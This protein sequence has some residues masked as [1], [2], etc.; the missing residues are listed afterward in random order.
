ML[1]MRLF[2]GWGLC[3][4]KKDWKLEGARMSCPKGFIKFTFWYQYK[5]YKINKSGSGWWEISCV[6]PNQEIETIYCK[7]LKEVKIR[8]DNLASNSVKFIRGI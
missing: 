4:Y 2:G 5:G 8:I 7:G 1:E 3:Y 6:L